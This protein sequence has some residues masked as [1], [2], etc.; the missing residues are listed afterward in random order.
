MDVILFVL[1]DKSIVDAGRDHRYELAA[2]NAAIQ[3]RRVRC[4]R[5]DDGSS[6]ARI[7][8]DRSSHCIEWE[9]RSGGE[10]DEES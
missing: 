9:E 8:F 5:K 2:L 10:C 3:G 4:N 7:P 1:M 6:L